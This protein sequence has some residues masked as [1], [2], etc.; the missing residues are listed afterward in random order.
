MSANHLCGLRQIQILRACG[1]LLDVWEMVSR[2]H[3]LHLSVAEEVHGQDV[4]E[5]AGAGRGGDRRGDQH[6]QHAMAVSEGMGWEGREAR[7]RLP[8]LPA[9]VTTLSWRAAISPASP[10]PCARVPRPPSTRARLLNCPISA[11]Q[12]APQHTPISK[13]ALSPWVS[14]SSVRAL[15]SP[16]PQPGNLGGRQALG[17]L[18]LLPQATQSSV[19]PCHLWSQISPRCPLLPSVPSPPRPEPPA[20]LSWQSTAACLHFPPLISNLLPSKQKTS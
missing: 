7:A 20:S 17:L 5:Y 11:S 16:Q 19:K 1:C 10:C 8:P 4:H 9:W 13:L 2:G 14:L 6:D 15:P 18:S 3:G 12:L